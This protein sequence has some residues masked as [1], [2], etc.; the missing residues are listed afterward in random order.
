VV[1]DKPSVIDQGRILVQPLG[2]FIIR[3]EI[4]LKTAQISFAKLPGCGALLFRLPPLGA[5]LMPESRSW[6]GLDRLGSVR[7]VVQPIT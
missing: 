5:A 2:R 7:M 1:A 4:V 3:V 6:I